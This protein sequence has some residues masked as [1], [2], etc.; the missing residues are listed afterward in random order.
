MIA[1]SA[2]STEQKK[3]I[4]FFKQKVGGGGGKGYK[5]WWQSLHLER[6]NETENK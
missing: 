1:H 2:Q 4:F 6:V 3:T 5:V